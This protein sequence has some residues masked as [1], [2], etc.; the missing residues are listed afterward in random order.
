MTDV[1]PITSA[2]LLLL[3]TDG[4]DPLPRS[5]LRTASRLVEADAPVD[6]VAMPAVALARMIDTTYA[7]STD[8]LA[9]VA[10]DVRALADTP[11]RFCRAE[12]DEVVLLVVLAA[13]DPIVISVFVH[14]RAAQRVSIGH[15]PLERLLRRSRSSNRAVALD[16]LRSLSPEATFACHRQD[17]VR[18]ASTF[19]RKYSA[20]VQSGVDVDGLDEFVSALR[21]QNGEAV[22]LLDLPAADGGLIVG[23]REDR[24]EVLA[25]LSVRGL[26]S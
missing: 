3:L 10:D 12:V 23:I 15:E 11:V 2:E 5:V 6:V 20:A 17:A 8:G 7:E 25:V 1:T 18:T 16:A 22:L 4:R 14:D 21:R 26:Q 13:A 19:E 9:R 24:S